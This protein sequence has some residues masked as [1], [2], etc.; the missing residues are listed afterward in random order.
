MQGI[1][2]TPE[3][4]LAMYEELQLKHQALT[5]LVND[6]RILQKEYFRKRDPQV[7]I[8]S[9]EAESKLDNF[10]NPKPKPVSQASIDFL[11]R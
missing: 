10:L 1:P 8:K 9:K 4:L 11:G 5:K 3:Q 2:V 6:V 7:L